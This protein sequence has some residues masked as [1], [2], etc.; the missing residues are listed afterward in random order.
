MIL[1]KILAF[2]KTS[3]KALKIIQKGH[4]HPFDIG[5]VNQQYF[6]Y[7]LA[8]G[9]FAHVSYDTDQKTRKNMGN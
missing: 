7:V 6:V 8:L 2:Q 5:K 3:K 4:V 9:S 1:L